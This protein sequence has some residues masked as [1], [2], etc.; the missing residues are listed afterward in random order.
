[1]SWGLQ[2][3]DIKDDGDHRAKF[4]SMNALGRCYYKA[5]KHDAADSKVRYLFLLALFVSIITSII[6]TIILV[7][8]VF[9]NTLGFGRCLSFFNM[10]SVVA[11]VIAVYFYHYLFIVVYY[12]HYLIIV[13]YYCHYRLIDLI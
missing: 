3:K 10:I 1:V 8:S 2:A 6:V 13:V 9:Q 4:K 5:G 12:C 11:P 7:L